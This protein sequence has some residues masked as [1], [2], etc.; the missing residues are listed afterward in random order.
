MNNDMLGQLHAERAA[1]RGGGPPKRT[2]SSSSSPPGAVGKRAQ[3][4]L[5]AD[6]GDGDGGCPRGFDAD[7]WAALDSRT[8]REICTRVDQEQQRDAALAQSLSEGG[9]GSG[10]GGGGG[11]H[12]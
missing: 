11:T 10:G 12:C 5:A 6:G 9:G 1:R 2:R 3:L 8:K 7:D 4:G